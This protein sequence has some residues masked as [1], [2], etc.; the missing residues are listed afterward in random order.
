MNSKRSYLDTLNAGRQRRPNVAL[1]ELNRSLE[2]L[3]QRLERTREERAERADPRRPGTEPRY[4][5][6]QP[7][8]QPRWYE[9]PHPAQRLKS[10]APAAPAFD[11]KYQTIARDIDRVRGQE[12]SVAVVGKIAGEL[13]GLREELRHQMTVGLQRE[14]DAL[15]KDIERA[16]QASNQSGGQSGKGSAELGVEFERLS[17]A[18]QTLAEKSDD[19]SVNMLRL[20]LE[21]VKAALDTLA[22]EESVQAVDRRWDDFDRR[23]SAFED[24]V[25]ADQRKRSDAP[26]FSMLTDR[27]EQISNAVNNLPE[28]L[29]LRSLEDKVRTLTGAVDHFAS[30]QDNRGSDT[31]GLN[32]RAA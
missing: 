20:E 2:T 17:G 19:R 24:R 12:D 9:D 3:E 22:R 1:E 32:R 26:G 13:R 28:S 29:S 25:D 14:F 15:R 23:W 4:A 27:L 16:F 30:Q 18:I 10:P 11:Q 6:A 5:S 7:Y 31:F 21:Q 8:G